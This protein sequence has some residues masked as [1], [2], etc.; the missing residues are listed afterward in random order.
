M[1]RHSTTIAGCEV[2]VGWDPPMQTYFGQVYDHTLEDEDENPIVWIGL[3][4]NV[5]SLDDL[6][7]QLGRYGTAVDV[8][9]GMLEQEANA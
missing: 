2:V 4:D 5:T 6:R 7:E 9:A 3:M 8:F 1:S